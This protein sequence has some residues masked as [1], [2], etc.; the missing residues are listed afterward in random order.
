MIKVIPFA[1][2][3]GVLSTL[4]APLLPRLLESLFTVGLDGICVLLDEKLIREKDRMIWQQRTEGAFHGGLSL[5]DIA[6]HGLAIY[7]VK[8][9]NSDDCIG[10]IK[11]LGLSLLING[12]T[13][14]KLNKAILQTIPQGV[15][16]VH[17]GILPKYRGASCVEWA[18]YNDERVGN[19]SHFMTEGYDEGPI[20]F[21]ESYDF[22]H[23]DTYASI[24]T[25]VYRESLRLTA[26]TVK[27]VFSQGL[28]MS[29]F[30]QQGAGELFAPISDEKMQVVL[31]KVANKSYRYMGQN[32]A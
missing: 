3:I 19:T 18:I 23:D 13:P 6:Q 17:P 5:Y 9:H 8:S 1:P 12:G 22:T 4:T 26:E 7:P 27:V 28:T 30:Q 10:L 24:R 25:K 14:R 21:S 2:R 16:N 32:D 11:L 15:I 20:I 29:D 31:E